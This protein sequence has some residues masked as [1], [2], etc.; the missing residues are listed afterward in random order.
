MT[1]RLEEL[2]A[3]VEAATGPD[4]ELNKLAHEAR[5]FCVHR[6]T[7]YYCIEDGNDYD[8][9]H[10]CLACGKD[11]YGETVP[12]YTASLDAAKSLKHPGDLWCVGSMEDG[13]FARV[14]PALP[15]GHYG[16]EITVHA[17]TVE[18]ALTAAFL[19]A[20]A[21]RARSTLLRGKDHG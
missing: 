19:R 14:V 3:R 20:A 5:G 1:N 21:L 8:S 13:P 9:G 6:E 2:A 11:A 7:R 18:N 17:E 15:G 12:N 4:R 16:G 10:A